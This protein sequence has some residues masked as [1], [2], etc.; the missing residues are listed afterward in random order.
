MWARGTTAEFE[1]IVTRLR[2]LDESCAH[3]LTIT[4]RVSRVTRKT[5]VALTPSTRCHCSSSVSRTALVSSA[6]A[7]LTRP[8]SGGMVAAISSSVLVTCAPSVTE[9]LR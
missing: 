4:R 5:P 9:Q 7:A 6:P 2:R 8:S 1:E 3:W